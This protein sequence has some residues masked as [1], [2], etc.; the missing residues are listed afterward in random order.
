MNIFDYALGNTRIQPRLMKIAVVLALSLGVSNA[1]MANAVSAATELKEINLLSEQGNQT[2]ALE[3]VN[4]YLSANPKDAEALFMKGVI[5]VEQGKR[6]EA[7]KAFTD[8]TEKYPNL[9]E[10]YNNL[11]VLYA[12]QGQYDKARKALETAIKTHPSYATAHE[13]LGDI[14]ARLASEAYDK[15]FKLDTS[16]ARAQSKLSMI[17]DLFGGTKTAASKPVVVAK[18]QPKPADVVTKPITAA[19]PAEVKKPEVTKPAEP[20]VANQEAAILNAV[21]N[22]ASAWSDKNVDKYLSSYANN[23][24]TPKG[25]SRKAWENTRRDR[26]GRPESISVEVNDPTVTMEGDTEAK[27]SFRQTYKANGK[28]QSTRKTLVMTKANNAWLIKQEIAG[29]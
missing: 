5:L 4:T 13:N 2:A 21:N 17:T 16:N 29:R 9:P 1:V 11:A 23:F 8:L 27:V 20:V 24:V 26:V 12:D 10:P 25:E 15:A 28:P 18:N 22:W 6:D 3:K 14:Y 7:I 19:K